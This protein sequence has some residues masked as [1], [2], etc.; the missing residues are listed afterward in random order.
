[1]TA[2]PPAFRLSKRCRLLTWASALLLAAGAPAFSKSENFIMDTSGVGKTNGTIVSSDQFLELGVAGPNALR[3][4]G[5][6]S[7]RMGNLDRAIT[8]LQRSVEMA[9][10]D[11]DGR[12]LYAEALEKKLMKQEEKD[13]KL[14]NFLVKQW[15]FVFKKSEFPDQAMQGLQHVIELT[16]TQPKRMEGVPKFLAR[17]LLPEDGSTKVALG[18]PHAPKEDKS[19]EKKSEE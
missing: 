14:F 3:L 7:L 8:V 12:I 19:D 9:P 15:L 18:G 13:R 11:M 2:Y 6:Q 5:E 17:V 10:L 4:E 1:M 16:G